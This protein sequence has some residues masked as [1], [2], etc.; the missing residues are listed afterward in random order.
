MK[1]LSCVGTINTGSD[2]IEDMHSI[3]LYWDTDLIC[4]FAN[5][6]CEDWFKIK[7]ID[8]IDKKNMA[9]L[10]GTAYLEKTQS[11]NKE[12]LN[13][14]E[15]VFKTPIQ[16]PYGEI[17]N[18][19][20]TY[21]PDNS[22]GEI[23][24][25]YAHI[26]DISSLNN[27]QFVN[28]ISDDSVSAELLNGQ[29]KPLIEILRFLK[30]NL[31]TGFPGIAE[32]AK[33]SYISESKLKRDFKEIYGKSPFDYYRHLQMELAE[34]YFHEKKVTKKQMAALLNFSNPSNFS[35][36]YRK[37]LNRTN[38]PKQIANSEK[39][40]NEYYHAFVS[41]LPIAAAMFDNQLLFITA[42]QKW[43]DGN[44]LEYSNLKSKSLF[45]ILPGIK[46]KYE[47]LLCQCLKGTSKNT[48]IDFPA[49]EPKSGRWNII[50]WIKKNGNIGGL[51]ISEN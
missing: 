13:G 28:H 41:Q 9:D 10:F 27:R 3:I 39:V 18:A 30:A 7:P 49:D 15:Q 42:S 26:V 25:F 43:I 45:E 24:G 38:P 31:T 34:K 50:S 35:A 6:A 37:Y 8:I 47:K 23:K 4:R 2:V 44:Q 19:I 46:A 22:F 29:Y 21:S 11:F 14:R 17:R 48:V 12:I 36:C 33:K 16:I 1:K 51:I 5:R 20:V 40:D 32:L